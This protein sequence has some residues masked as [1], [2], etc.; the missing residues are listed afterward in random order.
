M[1][2][3]PSAL[4]VFSIR[5]VARA[6][7]VTDGE[8]RRAVA[9]GRA[10]TVRD[11]FFTSLEAR[12]LVG[13]YHAAR[14]QAVTTVRPELFATDRTAPRE[15]R[16]PLAASTSVHG[17]LLVAVVLWPLLGSATTTDV[18]ALVEASPVR[19]VFLADPG[20]GGGGGGGGLRQPKPPAQVR[21][22]GDSQ[23]SSPVPPPP[24][25]PAA[26]AEHVEPPKPDPPPDPEPPVKAPV[27]SVPADPETR[28]GVVRETPAEDSKGPGAG[29]GSGTGTGTGMGEG[30]GSG[31]GEG[32]GGGTGGGPYRP[33]SGIEPPSIVR[34][35]KPEYSEDARRRSIEGDVVLEIVVRRDGTVSDIRVVRGLGHGLDQRAAQAVGQ[36]RF[37]PARRFGTPVD[38]IVEVSVEFKLR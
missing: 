33:G 3:V 35:V 1:S 21:R 12:R 2:I 34:E 37:A 11:G 20:P 19:L 25:P 23:L 22:Q 14:V 29:G 28:P 10:R 15:A 32:S 6:A 18:A 31:I 38:V 36:W 4:E 26:E 30:Q 24:P 9:E 8:V 27:A 17:M 7:G 13:A 16:V 5:E